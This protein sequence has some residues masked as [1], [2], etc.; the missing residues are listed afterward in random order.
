MAIEEYF[1]QN[2]VQYT[3]KE[4]QRLLNNKMGVEPYVI[5]YIKLNCSEQK[6]AAHY[7]RKVPFHILLKSMQHKLINKLT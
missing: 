7:A 4:F 1:L 2:K 5:E 6:K 3:E